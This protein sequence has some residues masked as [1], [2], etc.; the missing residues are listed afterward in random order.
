MFTGII[1][2]INMAENAA[3]LQPTSIA[4]SGYLYTP[5]GRLYCSSE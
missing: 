3:R 4:Q 1:I 2:G 5:N